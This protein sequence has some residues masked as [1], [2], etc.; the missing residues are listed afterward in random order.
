MI[1]SLS[2]KRIGGAAMLFLGVMLHSAPVLAQS[3]LPS[4]DAAVNTA[5]QWAAL[6]DSKQS[7]RMW[8][9]SGS[10]MKNSISKEQWGKFLADTQ[11]QNGRITGRQWAQAIRIPNPTN[12]PPGEYLNV[13]FAARSDKIPMAVEKISLVQSGGQWVPIGYTFDRVDAVP[14]APVK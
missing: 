12:L 1:S 9:L 11:N 4:L 10:T 5:L 3:A 7:E 6:A 8:S 14:A 13:V 2:I